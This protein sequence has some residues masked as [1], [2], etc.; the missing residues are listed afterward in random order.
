MKFQAPITEEP[1][2]RSHQASELARQSLDE[3]VTDANS[4]GWGTDE[5]IV[6]FVDAATKLKDANVKDPDPAEDPD[7]SDVPADGGQLG[8]GERFD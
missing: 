6:A 5:I 2:A 7:I 4:A 8:H 1:L 3:L